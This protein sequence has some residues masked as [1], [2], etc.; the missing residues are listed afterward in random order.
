MKLD[1]FMGKKLM[2]PNFSKKIYSWKKSAKKSSKIGLLL[3]I[4]P[5]MYLFLF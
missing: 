2:E 5:L 4:N 3:K 1:C